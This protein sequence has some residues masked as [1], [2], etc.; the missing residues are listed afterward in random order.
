MKNNNSGFGLVE[1]MVAAGIL[2][3]LAVVL[4]NL[5]KQS[6]TTLVKSKVDQESLLVVN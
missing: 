5:N 1:V 2:G 6:A 3:A 4:M